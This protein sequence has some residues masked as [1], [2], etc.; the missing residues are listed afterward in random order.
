MKIAAEIS[1]STAVKHTENNYPDIFCS[2]LKWL[3]SGG[4]ELK[5]ELD[6]KVNIQ[7]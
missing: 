2:C 4:R 1:G 6:M 5:E 7:L 3:F